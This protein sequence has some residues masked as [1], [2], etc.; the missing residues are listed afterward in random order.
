MRGA[1]KL[2][3]VSLPAA[4]VRIDGQQLPLALRGV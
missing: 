4:A 2:P 1:A 3:S